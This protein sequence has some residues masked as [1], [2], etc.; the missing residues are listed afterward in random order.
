[1]GAAR[2]GERR[3]KKS[4]TVRAEGGHM[5]HE[6]MAERGF[7]LNMRVRRLVTTQALALGPVARP[8]W[9]DSEDGA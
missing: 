9:W 4:I 3:Q 7:T 2:L 1:M 6:P 8:W 5:G